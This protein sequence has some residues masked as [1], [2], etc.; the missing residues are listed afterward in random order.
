MST[1]SSAPLSHHTQQAETPLP[2]LQ[3][4]TSV[5]P[6]DDPST[7]LPTTAPKQ[8]T[9]PTITQAVIHSIPPHIPLSPDLHRNQALTWHLIFN[10]APLEHLKQIDTSGIIPGVQPICFS[11]VKYLTCSA[12]RNAAQTVLPHPRTAHR[13]VSLGYSISSDTIVSISPQSSGKH[14]HGSTF[15][16]MRI[17]SRPHLYLSS[18]RLFPK[19]LQMIAKRHHKQPVQFVSDNAREYLAKT[20]RMYSYY[21]GCHDSTTVPH[22]PEINAL[23]E[24]IN[25]TLL[26]AARVALIQA[27]LP[28]KYWNF[29]ALDVAHKYNKCRTRP[30]ERHHTKNGTM[31]TDIT[32][33]CSHLARSA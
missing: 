24:R 12:C 17:R 9:K 25:R 10:H 13:T 29:A 5:A 1:V 28:L 30:Q 31:L 11:T 8:T 18:T 23:A 7:T 6:V 15:M 14:H 16:D 20:I 22:H 33:D 32:L 26:T 19:T 2:D 21:N 3:L 4:P 27:R